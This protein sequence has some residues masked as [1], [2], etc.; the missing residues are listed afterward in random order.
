M[1]PVGPHTYNVNPTPLRTRI[2]ET[3]GEVR[4]RPR[5]HKARKGFLGRSRRRVV[6]KPSEPLPGTTDQQ[7]DRPGT[8][9]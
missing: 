8:P 1:I 7:E 5:L 9:S 3:V 6:A 2:G 4:A